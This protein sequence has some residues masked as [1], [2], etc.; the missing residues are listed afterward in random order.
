MGGGDA[1]SP[2]PQI[3]AAALKQAQLGEDYLG[4]VKDQLAQQ[5]PIQQAVADRA[6]AVADQQ[7]AASKETQQW[8][9]QDRDRYKS[10]F[11]PLQDQFIDEAKKYG[12]SE[13]QD[14]QAGQARADVMNNAAMAAG[15][16]SR[17]EASMGIDPTS[18]R[19]AGIERGADTSTALGA[20]S[21]EN[22]ARDTARN[23]ALALDS[24]AINMGNGMP[25]QALQES[26]TGT[27]TGSASIGSATTP[28][29]LQDQALGVMGGGYGAASNGYAGEASTLNQ[30]Y[31]SQLSAWQAQ[32]QATSGLMSGLGSV[33]GAAIMAS[34]KTVKT[35][36]RPAKNVLDAVR[37]M[38]VENWKYK[39]GVADGGEHIGPYAEDFKSATGKGDGKS[40]PVVD[41]I[42]VSLG[43]I[44][45]LADKVD[46]VSDTVDRM[47]S[48]RGVTPKA[49]GRGAIAA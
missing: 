10:V 17:S 33:A 32:Q 7:L 41:A 2:D 8:A 48:A 47:S 36:K 6:N 15:Q 1:P 14:Q 11:Q 38:P 42:G 20:V 18:G 28:I 5:Q 9:E 37:K 46:K 45:E 24:Q 12:S 3:G 25:M 49:A 22:A 29:N 19:Y 23:K 27:Q 21:A 4:I 31:Q 40:I 35:N 34:S 39:P 13:Y 30:E 26:T 43:A 44:R 16:R